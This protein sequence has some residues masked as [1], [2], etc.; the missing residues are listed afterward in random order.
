MF[1]SELEWAKA[2]QNVTFIVG[3][4]VR[5]TARL[6]QW[7]WMQISSLQ[8]KTKARHYRFPRALY[9]EEEIAEVDY[10]GEFGD[11]HPD[12]PDKVKARLKYFRRLV[13]ALASDEITKAAEALTGEFTQCYAVRND[14]AHANIVLT[15]SGVELNNREWEA[16]GEEERQKLRD[17]LLP[18]NPKLYMKKLDAIWDLRGG[19][20]TYTIHRLSDTAIRLEALYDELN[21][22]VRRIPIKGDP[23]PP[24]RPPS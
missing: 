24:V 9:T 6:D 2:E 11:F 3:R 1:N 12:A 15:G 13:R 19:R 14:V 8:M 18:H 7:I 4:I 23:V 5:A 17:A 21:D 16:Q 10:D 22:L 20:K